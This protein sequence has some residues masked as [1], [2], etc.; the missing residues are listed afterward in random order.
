MNLGDKMS[1]ATIEDS[2]TLTRADQEADR[3]YVLEDGTCFYT[4]D[5]EGRDW[6]DSEDEAWEQVA[7][8]ETLYLSGDIE[9]VDW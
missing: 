8:A 7:P 4:V 9:V 3:L 1:Q 2:R 5:G 6:Y